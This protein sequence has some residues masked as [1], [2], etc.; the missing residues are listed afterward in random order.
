MIRGL[1]P[2]VTGVRDPKLP[3][4]WYEGW[5]LYLLSGYVTVDSGIDL[6]SFSSG[7]IPMILLEAQIRWGEKRTPLLF[8]FVM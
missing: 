6:L 1:P 3:R 5:L 2:P 8:A 7:T 4:E